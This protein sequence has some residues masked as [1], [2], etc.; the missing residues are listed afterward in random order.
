MYVSFRMAPDMMIVRKNTN[1]SHWSLDNGYEEDSPEEVYPLRVIG[2]GR[3]TALELSINL[4]L[5]FFAEDE[6]I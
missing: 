6:F 2:S 5:S 4:F 3:S 1:V